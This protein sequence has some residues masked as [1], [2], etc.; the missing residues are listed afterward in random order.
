MAEIDDNQGKINRRR[1]ASGKNTGCC[2]PLLRGQG[3]E[4]PYKPHNRRR[5]SLRVWVES[6]VGRRSA[7]TIDNRKESG[8]ALLI[9]ESR[10]LQRRTAVRTR[11][12]RQAFNQPRINFATRIWSLPRS[13]EISRTGST[14]FGEGVGRTRKSPKFRDEGW[15]G[16]QSLETSSSAG[17]SDSTEFSSEDPAGYRFEQ[18][19]RRRRGPVMV[20][21]HRIFRSRRY[22]K[23][24]RLKRLTPRY[25]W[26]DS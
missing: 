6:P 10:C 16:K 21:G 8:L 26:A 1:T 25:L 14:A 7:A 12:T 24:R 3:V 15:S 18:T 4:L 22:E 13:C 2:K 19:P 20:G 23:H 5:P 9:P 11:I 17:G